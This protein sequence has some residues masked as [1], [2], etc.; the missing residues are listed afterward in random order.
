MH[1]SIYSVPMTSTTL[2]PASAVCRHIELFTD[3][4]F[5]RLGQIVAKSGVPS[6]Q[7][8]ER[9][10]RTEALKIMDM[11]REKNKSKEINIVVECLVGN[12]RDSIQHLV[13]SSS[14]ELAPW[15]A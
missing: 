7:G 3:V 2:S 15:V 11:I 4:L 6:F 8:Q 1:T 13:G 14:H 9:A 12:I 10:A 5:I